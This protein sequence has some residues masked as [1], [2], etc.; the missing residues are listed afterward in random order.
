MVFNYSLDNLS[1]A[2]DFVGLFKFA[3]EVTGEVFG[4]IM[5][6]VLFVVFFTVSMSYGTRSENAFLVASFTTMMSS[7]LMYAMGLVGVQIT[8]LLLGMTLIGAFVAGRKGGE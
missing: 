6:F 8:I 7:W 1:G 5:L 4:L 3:N 2:S